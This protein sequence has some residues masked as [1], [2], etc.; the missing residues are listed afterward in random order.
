LGGRDKTGDKG[1]SS[2]YKD[3]EFLH[4]HMGYK[5]TIPLQASN[6][7]AWFLVYKILIKHNFI[8]ATSVAA[9][10]IIHFMDSLS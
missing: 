6:V 8:H 5:G 7:K 1:Q 9:V 4:R 2:Q 3:P 10:R